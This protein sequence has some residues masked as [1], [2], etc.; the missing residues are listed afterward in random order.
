MYK[1]NLIEINVS[2]C[3]SLKRIYNYFFRNIFVKFHWDI[4]SCSKMCRENS[5]RGVIVALELA[6]SS[7]TDHWRAGPLTQPGEHCSLFVARCSH[8]RSRRRRLASVG[9]KSI[10]I[11]V[12]R[13]TD[14]ERVCIAKWSFLLPAFITE[15]NY[16][17]FLE[18]KR[19]ELLRFLLLKE[20]NRKSLANRIILNIKNNS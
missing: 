6:N 3:A 5:R 20:I 16:F 18:K 11:R 13:N 15:Q 9:W 10:R 1:Y 19:T 7:L 12:P 8:K 17:V 14:I 4:K 2:H